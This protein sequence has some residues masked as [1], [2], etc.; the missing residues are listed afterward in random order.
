MK[1][2]KSEEEWAR[3][4]ISQT[5]SV[6]VEQH[7]DGSEDGMHDLW[8][9]HLDRPDA[10]VEITAAADPASIALAKLT[11]TGGRW[12]VPELRGGWAVSVAP[13]ALAKCLFKELP[14]FLSELEAAGETHVDIKRDQAAGQRWGARAQNLGITDLMQSEIP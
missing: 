10:A 7:D 9:K 12:V 4:I 6:P 8:I 1:A 14:A 13:A 3:T 2:L 11:T 5:L